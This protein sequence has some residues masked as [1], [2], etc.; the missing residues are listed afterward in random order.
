MNL[1]IVRFL[2]LILLNLIPFVASETFQTQNAILALQKEREFEKLSKE[3]ICI[4][5]TIVCIKGDIAECDV[6]GKFKIKECSNNKL[7][8]YVFPLSNNPGVSIA[9]G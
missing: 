8:C 1:I 5:G 2:G 4:P 3:D 7:R 6:T 9:C